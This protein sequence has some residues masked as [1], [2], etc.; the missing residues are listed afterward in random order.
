MRNNSHYILIH[1]LYFKL[2]DFKSFADNLLGGKPAGRLASG[3]VPTPFVVFL[4]RNN[5][6]IVISSIT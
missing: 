1:F 6:T 3:T 2:P 4:F 5:I